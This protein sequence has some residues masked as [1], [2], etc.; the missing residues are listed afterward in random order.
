MF[1]IIYYTII[2]ALYIGHHAYNLN[3]YSI[4]D[5]LLFYHQSMLGISQNKLSVIS[6]TKSKLV[7]PF[8]L[9]M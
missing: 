7:P 2:E 1:K 8:R 3:I 9:T 4:K 5:N 6:V